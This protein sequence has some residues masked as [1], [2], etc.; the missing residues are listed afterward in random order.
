MNKYRKKSVVIEAVQLLETNESI[1]E[2]EKFIS[3]KE[4]IQNNISHKANDKWDEYVEHIKS[5]GGRKIRTLESHDADLLAS[6]GDWIIKG[7]KGEF[8][9]CKN[10]IFLETYERVIPEEVEMIYVCYWV[11][12]KIV[13]LWKK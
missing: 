13:L 2:V 11:I 3:G 10:E 7:V 6:F 8:Y 9:P 5:Q 12:A 4:D 1:L